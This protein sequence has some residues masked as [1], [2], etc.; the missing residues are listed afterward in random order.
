M[1]K[2]ERKLESLNRNFG[3]KE[4]KFRMEPLRNFQ[5]FEVDIPEMTNGRQLLNVLCNLAESVPE[6]SVVVFKMKHFQ[7]FAISIHGRNTMRLNTLPISKSSKKLFAKY[8]DDKHIAEIQQATM[9]DHVD[10]KP[11]FTEDKIKALRKELP[12]TFSRFMEKD[13]GGRG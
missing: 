9:G 7:E 4:R 1:G 2:R 11:F 3:S 6:Q 12:E 13:I 8:F 10:L 5:Y